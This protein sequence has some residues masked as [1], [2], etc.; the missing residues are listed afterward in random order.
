MGYQRSTFHSM[1]IDIK[2]HQ[3]TIDAINAIL[4]NKDIAEVKLEPK[5]IAVVAIKRQVKSVENVK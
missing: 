2:K 5:G 3:E 4:S 1:N